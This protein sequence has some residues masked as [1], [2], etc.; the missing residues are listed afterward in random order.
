MGNK[1]LY[2]LAFIISG[3]VVWYG[4]YKEDSGAMYL[5]VSCVAAFL[6]LGLFLKVTN[7]NRRKK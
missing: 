2:G 3:F 6:F 5:G 4:W 7:K 1:L